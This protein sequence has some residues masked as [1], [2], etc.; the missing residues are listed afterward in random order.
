MMIDDKKTPK[1]LY[2][3]RQD[4]KIAGVCGGLADYFEIDP[5]WMRLLFLLLFVFGG[6]SFLVYLI[7]WIV[8]PLEPL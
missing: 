7:M 1:R 3:S 4:R 6:S 2:R 8:M 5:T